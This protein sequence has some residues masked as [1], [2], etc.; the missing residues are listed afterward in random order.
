MAIEIPPG[1]DD[2]AAE[3][4]LYG[5]EPTPIRIPFLEGNQVQTIGLG[6]P[7]PIEIPP[8][9]LRRVAR[10]RIK[11]A[12]LMEG[13]VP[14]GKLAP[15]AQTVQNALDVLASSSPEVPAA[16]AEELLLRKEEPP[17]VLAKTVAG[18][19]GSLLRGAESMTSPAMLATAG[20]TLAPA[21]V[22][23]VASGVFAAHM[24]SQVPEA[25]QQLKQAIE[26]K[27]PEKIAASATDLAQLGLFT[28]TAAKHAVVRGPETVL[29]ES[30]KAV[31]ESGKAPELATEPLTPGQATEVLRNVQDQSRLSEQDVPAQESVERVP[32]SNIPPGDIERP[33]P[34][35]K[36]GRGE[37]PLSPEQAAEP[38][39]IGGR[40]APEELREQGGAVSLAP[41]QALVT[42]ATPHVTEAVDF[43]RDIPEKV[44]NVSAQLSGKSAPITSRHAVESGNALVKYASSKIAAP[45]VAKNMATEVLGDRY[46]DYDFGNKLGAV[47]VEDRLRGIQDALKKS[48]SSN[49][50]N[51]IIGKQDSPFKTEA[52]FQAALADP[53]I[54]A[55][56]A[57]HKQIIQPVA[58]AAHKE[59]GGTFAGPGLNTGA[60]VNLKAIFEDGTGNL[61]GGGAGRGNLTNPLRRPSRFSKKASG[62]AQNYELDY[63]TIAQRM[64]E[65]NF[66]E[67]AKRKMY[68]RLVKDG[69]GQILD[70]SEPRPEIGGEPAVKF[71][72]ERKGTPAGG[73]KVRT[74]VKNLWVRADI[75]QEVRQALNVDGPVQKSGLVQAANLINR[76]QLAGPT[77]AVW[78]TA[79]MLG[80]IAGSQGGKNVLIDVARALPGVNI[81]DA[82]GR[83][84]A[85]S[86]RVLRDA[87][88]VQKQ[89]AEIAD[90]GALRS[91]KE[92]SRFAFNQKLI[93]MVDKAGRLV[94]DN[95]YKNLV[96]RG[97]VDDTP[98]NRREWINQMG[99]YNGRL[100]G[101]FQR[102]FKE[103]GFSPFIVAGRNFNRMAR[104]RLTLD[105]G[106]EASSPAAA[107][108]MRAVNFL[109]T[110]ATLFAIPALFNYLLT[111]SPNGR[112]GTKTGQIDSGKDAAG[113]KHIIID[114]AQ[115]TGLRRGMRIS[116]AQAVIEGL[117]EGKSAG[118]ITQ[119]A[120]KDMVGGVIHPWT[121]PAVTAATVAQTGYTPAMYKESEN[122]KDY[123]E[124]IKAALK[125]L[126]PLVNAYLE[127]KEKKTGAATQLGVSLSGAFG[128][129][130]QRGT[131]SLD[132]IRTLHGQWLADNKDQFVKAD[133]ERNQAATYP[134]SKYK[135]VDQ[136]LLD[137]DKKALAEAIQEL[138]PLVRRDSDIVER[139]Q[140]YTENAKTFQFRDKPLFQESH[141]LE[142]K[143]LET[144]TPEQRA[145][146]DAALKDR[147]KKWLIFLEVWRQRG[148][149]PNQP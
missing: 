53:E 20:L 88:D 108:Q 135:L 104:R 67:S 26:S 114:P 25:A 34:P 52:D 116:G 84:V 130:A 98:A 134:V 22:A 119:Q 127:G 149:R 2:Y 103:A 70:P 109:G 51:S 76:I 133:Y 63:R 13:L 140:P 148:P 71:Q 24:A 112:D 146:Y 75:A 138:R 41:I 66:E 58:R 37:I 56:I 85:S 83:V 42:K 60:F 15:S 50:V 101:Q 10:E 28:A 12:D 96:R 113:G 27:D 69:L 4:E 29:P 43:I 145:V 17:D 78:H 48:G 36:A 72:I 16:E 31:E 92:A 18:V 59:A 136:A 142:N 93:G 3:E 11:P 87:P 80:S 86:I 44:R 35:E 139:M 39:G 107:A 9:L 40:M 128:V 124:N 126:N 62:T 46:R 21:A 91:E 38:K 110:A 122:P 118:K 129:K 94:R 143:F 147:Q 14:L 125:Q 79:N 123:G 49:L 97:L 55:A 144:L 45:L 8:E 121:G 132:K 120:L 5:F 81:T 131:T 1:L 77:D 74:Y 95:L 73:G 82:I 68:A 33:P 100:M 99:Q 111:G 115:W 57:R 32:P 7:Q 106:I 141:T 19:E 61:I 65:G 105:P 137:N 6:Q 30:V 64:I 102:F 89:L 117:R 90:I 47:L 23:R 54:Q